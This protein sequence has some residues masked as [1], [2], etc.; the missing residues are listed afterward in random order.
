MNN[1]WNFFSVVAYC[2]RMESYSQAGH[3]KIYHENGIDFGT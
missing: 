1:T 3:I 2:V